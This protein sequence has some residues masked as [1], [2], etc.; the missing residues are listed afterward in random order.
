MNKTCVQLLYLIKSALWNKH[1]DDDAMA[2]CVIPQLLKEAK[3]QTV[4]G[5]VLEALNTNG[6]LSG[7]P[8]AKLKK[9]VGIAVRIEQDNEMHK[10]VV[11]KTLRCLRNNDI[12]VVFMKGLV[13]GSRYPNPNRRQCGDIDFVVSAECFDKTL[14]ALESIGKVNRELIHE[15][16]GM[17]FVDGIVVEPH[18]KVHNFQNPDVDNTMRE[19]FTEVFPKHLISERIGGEDVPIFPY[20]AE[21]VILVSHMVNHV[22]AEGLG[23][24][25][26]IDFMMFLDKK[27]KVIDWQLCYQYLQRMQMERAFRVFVRICERYLGFPASALSLTYTDKEIAFAD[28]LMDDIMQVGNF[29]QGKDYLGNNR[30]LRPIRSYLW[31]TQR[32]LKLGYLCP[33]E[34]KYWPVSKLTRYY[35]KLKKSK[36]K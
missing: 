14:N 23:L 6:L 30:V 19:I 21:C 33:A 36:N 22:Y 27:H 11:I 8:R 4:F 3:K 17:A 34:A 13:V 9:M 35:W 24:R 1:A 2:G 16:H 26:V 12:P 5:L 25:Q 20:E 28:K 29:G 7:C 18:Y 10:V 15:H 32:C 31:V